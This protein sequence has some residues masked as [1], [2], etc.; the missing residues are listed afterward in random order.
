MLVAQ[1]INDCV[2]SGIAR[3]DPDYSKI[4]TL[5]LRE[6]LWQPR[7]INPRQDRLADGGDCLAPEHIHI[8][9]HQRS[10]WSSGQSH[11]ST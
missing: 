4:S 1:L 11:E 3:C 6:E 8:M 7:S 10:Q 5:P 9:T 2:I